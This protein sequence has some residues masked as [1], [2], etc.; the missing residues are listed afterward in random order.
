MKEMCLAIKRSRK[1]QEGRKKRPPYNYYMAP[2]ETTT[3][4]KRHQDTGFLF[5]GQA[6]DSTASWWYLSLQKIGRT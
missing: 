3:E 5:P 2:T 1:E 4:E 6:Q